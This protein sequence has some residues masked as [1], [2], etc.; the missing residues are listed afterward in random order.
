MPLPEIAKIKRQ[1]LLRLRRQLN[2]QVGQPLQRE[3]G[4]AARHFRH[5]IQRVLRQGLLLQH[6]PLALY[7][8]LHLQPAAL[9]VPTMGHQAQM[10][11][12]CKVA[13]LLAS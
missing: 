4:E 9:V 12:G 11:E 3:Q 5:L 8:A 10:Q 7:Q 6:E 1:R 13:A 2:L